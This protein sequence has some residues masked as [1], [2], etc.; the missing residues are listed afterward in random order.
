MTPSQEEIIRDIEVLAKRYGL[1][2]KIEVLRILVAEGEEL[3]TI[4]LMMHYRYEPS[5]IAAF[6]AEWRLK[7]RTD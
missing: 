6:Q 2:S 5:V 7:N 3:P 4:E 1:D